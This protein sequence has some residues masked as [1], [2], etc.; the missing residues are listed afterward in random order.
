[1]E[2]VQGLNG[3]T[4]DRKLHD[5]GCHFLFFAI[6]KKVIL[7]GGEEQKTVHRGINR[8]LDGL[9]LDKNNSLEITRVALKSFLGVPLMSVPFHNRNIRESLLL[10]G[11]QILQP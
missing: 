6:E 11:G 9:K 8:I 10:P 5:A 7:F 1:M 4:L 3:N 2:T